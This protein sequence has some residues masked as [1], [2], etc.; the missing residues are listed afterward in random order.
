MDKRSKISCQTWIILL[1]KQ[2]LLIKFAASY[3]LYNLSKYATSIV[4]SGIS[5]FNLPQARKEQ[6][7]LL[8]L[9]LTAA[10][11]RFHC[12]RLRSVVQDDLNDSRSICVRC[13]MKY[14]IN[15]LIL[16]SCLC[17]VSELN[18][19]PLNFSSENLTLPA[20]HFC[21]I[22]SL[23]LAQQEGRIP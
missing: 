22:T 19:L 2:N 10:E 15:I 14:E 3:C 6:A 20:V 16:H 9:F 23:R 7:E 11:T 21:P 12:R 17:F 4:S 18:K 1:K 13:S 8:L 5:K